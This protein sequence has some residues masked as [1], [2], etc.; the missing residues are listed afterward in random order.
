MST[1]C[2]S[3]LVRGRGDWTLAGSRDQYPLDHP[4]V[5]THVALDV[6]VDVEAR[7]LWGTATLSLQVVAPDAQRLALDARD[8]TVLAVRLDGQP[9]AF[10]HTGGKIH[11]ELPAPLPRGT[12]LG[13]AVDYRVEKPRLGLYFVAPDS[14]YPH[15]PR[16]AWTQGQDDDSAYWFPCLDAPHLKA[17]SEVR[18]TV[19]PPFR[20]LSNGPRVGSTANADGT[21]TW[22]H[23]LDVPHPAYLCTLVVGEFAEVVRHHG[24]LPV[25]WFVPPGREDDAERSLGK[26]PQMIAHFEKLLGV[27]FPYP[28]Y[29][30][31]TVADFVFGG[32]ENAGATTLMDRTLHDARAHLDFSSEELV[33]HELAHQWFGDLVTCR[34]WSEGWLNEGFATYF[35]ALWM[36][37]EQGKDDFHYDLWLALRRYMEEDGKRYRRPI[38]T[39]RYQEPIDLFDRHL[40]E[41]GAR[42]LHM[43][44]AELGDAVFFGGLTRYLQRHARGSADTDD[45]RRALEEEAGRSLERFFDDWVRADGHPDVTVDHVYD[46]ANKLAL[47][48]ISVGAR[49]ELG[50][51]WAFSVPVRIHCGKDVVE[52]RLK[53]DAE[54]Q[55]FPVKVPD[56]PTRVVVDGDDAVLKALRLRLPEELLIDQLRKDPSV[57]AR[58]RAAWALQDMPSRATLDALEAALKEDAFWGVQA[59]VA[60][61]LGEMRGERALRILLGALT[62]VK[63]PKARRAVARALGN[64]QHPDAA[65]A[66]EEKLRLGDDSYFV[67]AD[68]A[69]A[70]G[71]TRDPGAAAVLREILRARDS[72]LDVV[73]AGCVAG[74]GETRDITQYEVVRGQAEYGHAVNVRIAAVAAMARLGQG[75]PLASQVVSDLDRLTEDRDFRVTMAI[76][77]AAEALQD[78]AAVPVVERLQRQGPDGRIRRRAEEVARALKAGRDGQGAVESLRTELDKLRDEQR[79]LR[80]RVTALEGARSTTTT[81]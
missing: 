27:P 70:L 35:A 71:R 9:A 44:R 30:Q 62:S 46:A 15:K 76:L 48:N 80:D 4:V 28:E 40:Y 20:A 26:T 25:R 6:R 14:A 74:L 57:M 55:R 23:R 32:M 37:A 51:P 77:G 53:V 72:W 17:T 8:M 59:D 18:C 21:V 12:A 2:C 22:H 66:L 56:R 61:V 42:V 33:A 63:H 78:S 67:E 7:A 31:V 81:S 19:P 58:V 11:V 49:P 34:T 29:A 24:N 39:R 38:V 1:E 64:W 5:P 73:R 69:T 60:G 43:L 75:R 47:V 10:R 3:G 50:R 54:F 68:A 36:E 41:K 52:T 13:V 79:I 45:L 65:R 16:Q